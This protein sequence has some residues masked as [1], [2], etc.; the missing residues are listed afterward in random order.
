MPPVAFASSA[1]LAACAPAQPTTG[2]EDSKAQNDY[3]QRAGVS[4]QR[5]GSAAGQGDTAPQTW[6]PRRQRHLSRRRERT[7]RA[8]AADARH[9]YHHHMK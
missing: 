3:F 9:Q 4:E 1:M 5:R 8:R 6:T 7:T 2:D